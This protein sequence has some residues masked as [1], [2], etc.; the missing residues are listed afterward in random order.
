MAH[1]T[2]INGTSYEIT[3]GKCLVN[4]TGYSI[5]NGK[6]LVSG[7]GYDITLKEEFSVTLDENSMWNAGTDVAFLGVQIE[8]GDNWISSVGETIVAESGTLVSVKVQSPGPVN[9]YF[10]GVSVV[11]ELDA[12]YQFE[13]RANVSI[14]C[15]GFPV[16]LVYIVTD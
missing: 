14:T 3:G 12:A 11:Y 1:G 6:T 7:T 4:G 9:I 10:N 16:N 15:E 13:L 8:V 5:K 2:R